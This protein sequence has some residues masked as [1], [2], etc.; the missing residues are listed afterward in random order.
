ME[1]AIALPWNY[2][3]NSIDYHGLLWLIFFPFCHM[4]MFL[5]LWWAVPATSVACR[6][7]NCQRQEGNCATYLVLSPTS[8]VQHQV[9]LF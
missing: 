1:E 9:S 6:E 5:G 7:M 4:F 8:R 3:L 2:T